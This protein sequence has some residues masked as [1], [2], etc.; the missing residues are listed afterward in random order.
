M[1]NV[2][3]NLEN[4]HK[5]YSIQLLGHMSHVMVKG[6]KRTACAFSHTL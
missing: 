1:L 5:S 6:L 4:I 2:V 3:N